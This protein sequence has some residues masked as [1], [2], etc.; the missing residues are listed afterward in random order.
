M[1]ERE[2]RGNVA[3]AG[4]ELLDTDGVKFKVLWYGFDIALV[5]RGGKQ[6]LVDLVDLDLPKRKRPTR[7]RW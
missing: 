1:L 2:H 4:G 5:S 6:S 3:K 7:A